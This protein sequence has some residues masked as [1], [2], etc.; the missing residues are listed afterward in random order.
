MRY[1]SSRGGVAPTLF[2]DALLAGYCAD[3]GLYVPEA[4]PHMSAEWLAGLASADFVTVAEATLRLFVG[5]EEVSDGELAGL[6]HAAFAT[7]HHPEVLPVVA[8]RPIAGEMPQCVKTSPAQKTETWL[9][10]QR[11]AP[12][13]MIAELFHGQTLAFKDIGQGLVCSLLELFARK[14]NLK[15]H[16]LV[17]T[18]G[19]TGPAAIEATRFHCKEVQVT[20]AFPL[21]RISEL[22]RR[23]MTTVRAPNIRVL[24]FEGEGDDLDAP[25]KALSLDLPFRQK[26]GLCSI[27]SINVG[28]VVTQTAH[29]VWA[30]L[31]AL[32]GAHS[33]AQSVTD[34]PTAADFA[35]RTRLCRVVIIIPTGAMGNS[36]AGLWC[37]AS[38]LPVYKLVLATNAN[39]AVV[40]AVRD[41][42]LERQPMAHT[43]SE[44][45]NT[46]LP[47]NFER[48]LHLA[49]NGDCSRVRAWMAAVDRNEP[50]QLEEDVLFWLRERLLVGA[51]DNEKTLKCIRSTWAEYA[52]AIDPHTAVGLEV[53]AVM[54][55]PGGSLA[56]DGGPPLAPVC[57]AT[58][59][60]CKS[61]LPRPACPRA[62]VGWRRW[63]RRRARHYA[64]ART[65]PRDCERSSRAPGC[66]VN[67]TALVIAC[68]PTS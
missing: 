13:T 68:E 51:A 34:A 15:V 26:H 10:Q 47:Y 16:V 60:P 56:E 3:G 5:S 28:R 25:I 38:G 61:G 30:F 41:A 36:A 63:R 2:G 57:L 52:Y 62:R 43:V 65:G 18:T 40:R 53:L 29:H 23:Q 27:N 35:E 1:V 9:Q 42:M 45:M 39:D 31:R 17:S 37:V 7:F 48:L 4:M 50:L 64:R 21:G 8:L 49:A 46:Q 54:R 33:H 11:S 19:D 6:V 24:P 67:G 55:Q 20:A 32:E 59:H 66:P 12:P 14:R 22:Q 58:A 44:A